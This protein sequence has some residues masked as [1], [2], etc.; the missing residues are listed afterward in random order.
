MPEEYAK[1]LKSILYIFFGHFF[2]LFDNIM[3][4]HAIWEKCQKL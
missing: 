1:Y 4:K 3:C 2:L